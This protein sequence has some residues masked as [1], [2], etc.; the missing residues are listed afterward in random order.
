[1]QVNNFLNVLIKQIDKRVSIKF[2]DN[3][4]FD[5]DEKIER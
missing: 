2:L 3:H 4:K 1:M 5:L